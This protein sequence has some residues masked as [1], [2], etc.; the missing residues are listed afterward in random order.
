MPGNTFGQLFRITTWGESHGPALGVVADGCPSGLALSE[1]DIQKELDRRRP[2]QSRIV[3]SRKENDK[4]EILSGVFEGKTLGTPISIIIYNKD[5]RAKDYS[6]IKNIYRPGHADFT[7]QSKYGF[8]D[9]RGGGR[10]SGRETIGRVAG[11]AI[12]KKLL[13]KNAG[14]LIIGFTKQ[15]GD[16]A[17]DDKKIYLMGAKALLERCES[18]IVRCPDP[19]KAKEMIS[20]IDK[21]RKEG[22]SIGGVVEVIIKGAPV[23]LGGPV[24]DKLSADLAKALMSIPAV[25]GFEIGEGFNAVKA[26]GS[27][28]NDSYAVIGKKITTVTN[29]AGGISGGISNG[30][31]IV[32]RIAIKPTSSIRKEQDTVTQKGAKTKIKIEGRHDPCLCPRIVPVAESMAALVLA[33]HLLRS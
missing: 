23:G 8:R 29:H 26:K 28:N 5:A 3:T 18:N 27:E 19:N 30:Q 7:W 4:A 31:D 6:K 32:L 14:T 22:D 21:M 1:K 33:D 16:I 11:G 12:A 25:K 24:F 2:G 20:L 9:Y 13:S 10:S 15:V 17:V